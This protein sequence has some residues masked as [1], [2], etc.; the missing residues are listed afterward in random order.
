MSAPLTDAFGQPFPSDEHRSRYA[1]RLAWEAAGVAPF[2]QRY[3][4]DA[5]AGTISA[6]F[7][8]WEGKKVRLA[9]RIMAKRGQGKAAFLDLSDRSGRIQLYATIDDLGEESLD[10]LVRLIHAGDFLGIA[11]EVF[12]TRRGEISIRVLDYTLLSKA[13]H[14]LPEK[15]HGLTDVE[16]RFRRRYLD[17]I[18]NPASRQLAI[19]RA[20]IVQ[21]IRETLYAR[22]Y[23]EIETP[24]LTDV[25]SGAAA[26]PFNTHHN[27]LDWDLHLRISLELPL[28]KA[29]IGGLDRVFEIGRVFRNEGIDRDHS[30]EF[31]MI[32]LY[33]AFADYTVM[34]EITEELVYRC[35]LVV[36]GSPHLQLPDGGPVVDLTPPWP[37]LRWTELLALHAGV[38]L[39]PAVTLDDLKA[40]IRAHQLDDSD[41]AT[42]G[43][44]LDVLFSKCVEPHLTG[45]VFVLDYPIE[46]SPLAKQIPHEPGLTWRFE[47]FLAGMELGNAFTELN[48][49]EEQRRRFLHQA[50]EKA[51]GDD[52]A[53]EIDE[54]FLLAM[55]HGMPPA[56]GLG[57]GIDRLVMLLTG[58]PSLREVILFPLLKD[59]E[60]LDVPAT[61][62]VASP[63]QRLF[64]T[65]EQ[66]MAAQGVSAGR[67]M[68]EL[69]VAKSDFNGWRKGERIPTPEQVTALAAYLHLPADELAAM[70]DQAR[71]DTA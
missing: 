64:L 40:A 11:G 42:R 66:G 56:G 16:L 61:P 26:R 69:E 38:V 31:T 34:M 5:L 35:A 70:A 29:M 24:V 25:A 39:T 71:G 23:V 55:E 51:A 49:P 63:A 33:E 12:R 54:D 47:A 65:I 28:K 4:T 58:A 41:V 8:A 60:E 43:R 37:R 45:P 7:D 9:G 18:A 2:G 62:V 67:L 22:D 21:T 15:W 6:D 3:P 46:I 1:A 57:I 68:K 48:D 19:N 20:R 10:R 30:P 53:M 44:A 50:Q 32:E 13:L 52:E 27:A 36:N 17:L 59:K 14:P